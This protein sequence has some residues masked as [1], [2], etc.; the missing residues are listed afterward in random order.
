MTDIAFAINMTGMFAVGLVLGF[1]AGISIC[2][3]R[4]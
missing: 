2:T 3:W 1:L 4:T